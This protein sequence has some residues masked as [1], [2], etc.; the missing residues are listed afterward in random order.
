MRE[1]GHVKIGI[2]LATGF[3]VV[4]L[5]CLAIGLLAI[6]CGHKLSEITTQ[7]VDHPVAVNTALL[8]AD[9]DIMA[10]SRSMK[11]IAL[12]RNPADVDAAAAKV[13]ELERAIFKDLAL[14][15]ERIISDKAVVGALAQAITDWRPIR[16]QVISLSRQGK[17]VEAGEIT[18]GAGATQ[19]SLITEQI[20]AARDFAQKMS[21]QFM[22]DAAATRNDIENLTVGLLV[23]A[24]LL[25]AAMAWLTT[26]SITRPLATLRGSMSV[27]AHGD[28]STM[29]PMLDRRNEIGD[30]A[31]AV[32]VF[33]E[34]AIEKERLAA[35]QAHERREKERRAEQIERLT[36]SFEAT[37]GQL[38]GLL[39]STATEMEAT[40]ESMAQTAD[41]TNKQS[42]TLAVAAEQTSGNVQ[43][44]A[45][46]AEELAASIQEIG[47][48]V[49]QATSV[50]EKATDEAKRTDTTVQAMAASAQKIGEVVALIR[51]VANQTN[52][53]ALNATIEAARAGEHGKGFAV[54]ASE[55]KA[56]ANQTARATQ[57]IGNQITDIQDVTSK[58]VGAIQGIVSTIAE[59]SEIAVAIASAVEEQVAATAEIS[60]SVHQ[61]ANSTQDVSDNIAGVNQAA[62]DTG[63]AASEVHEAARRLSRQ[64]SD[65]TNHV[66]G[67]L[68]G[69]K[70]A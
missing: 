46:A 61:A 39:S 20:S 38:I 10:M 33:K 60:R 3:S 63:A 11:D 42:S 19:V 43:T 17:S 8:Q 24:V 67:F 65:L 64:S 66:T 53:L 49:S 15:N 4:L 36:G 13:S 59:V 31:R 47:R 57:D 58:A 22:S 18:N 25:G 1:L 5:L 2:R 69:I 35:E 9:R 26:T 45:T 56:L 68:G 41:R 21:A 62:T 55:V 14:A 34:Q 48:Q 23:A 50:A 7:M 70:S 29:V 54:V 30:M 44:V 40:A 12:S 6:H 28:N 37:V 32:Q 27:L 52:L 51:E 16:E